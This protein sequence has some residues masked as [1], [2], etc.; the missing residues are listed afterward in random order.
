MIVPDTSTMLAKQD[1]V[2]FSTLTDG[3]FGASSSAAET[4]W[5]TR[6]KRAATMLGAL[7]EITR[8]AE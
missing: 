3:P 6:Q 4:G 2:A 8:A 1:C 5:A 7:R